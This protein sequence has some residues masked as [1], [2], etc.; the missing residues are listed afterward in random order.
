MY[1]CPI[2][3]KSADLF[4]DT[5][6]NESVLLKYKVIGGGYRKNA[7]CP[8]CYSFE[9]TRLEFLYLKQ[10]TDVF[11]KKCRVLHF[12]PESH[13]TDALRKNPDIEYYSGDIYEGQAQLIVD[14][15]DICFED[16]KFDFVICNHVLEH[17]PDDKKAL[18]E[19][20]RVLKPGGRAVIM[21]PVSC[22]DTTQ[23]LQA[24]TDEERL[25]LYGQKDHVRLYGLDFPV[26]LK[27]AGLNVT[28]FCAD[29]DVLSEMK[30]RYALLSGE[31][32]YIGTKL[33]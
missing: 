5:G 4:L 30:D 24:V 33:K 3:E 17:I 23:E 20:K 10:Y 6:I 15:T 14:I 26:R 25:A 27:D 16:G 13:L 21:I 32:V 31:T 22:L 11:H 7:L 9:R 2:C 29:T 19:I 28:M 1:T 8:H 18:S 12:A